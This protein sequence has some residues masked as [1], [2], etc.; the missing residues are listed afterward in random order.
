[1]SNNYKR[2]PRRKSGKKFSVQ[3]LSSQVSKLLARNPKTRY[4]AKQ[5]IKKLKISNSKDSVAH[6]LNELAKDGAIIQ[7]KEGLYKWNRDNTVEQAQKV[8]PKKVYT[9]IVDLIQSGAAY[10]IV[11]DEEQ[12]IYIPKKFLR[13]AMNNDIVRVEMANIPGKRKPE[14]KVVDIIERSVTH[15]MGQLKETNKYGIVYPL[16][17]RG[18]PDEVYIKH[19]NFNGA[20]DGD[21]VVAEIITWG[22]SQN[23]A[24]W[25]KVK[26]IVEPANDSDIAMQSI[27]LNNGFEIEFPQQVLDQIKPMTAD[28]TPEEEKIRRDVRPVTTFTIDPLTARDFDD[29]LSFQILDDGQIEVGIHIA[30]VT[31]YVKENSPLDKEAR[32]RSTSVYLVDRVCPMLPEKL[33]NDLC[34][35]NPHVDRYTFSAIFTFDKDFKVTNRWFGKTIIHSDRRFT[36]EEAQEV[37]ESGKGDYADELLKLNE[38]AHKL[39]KDKYKN[40]AISFESDEIRF[41]LDDQG[42]PIGVTVKERKDAHMLVEDFM[43]LANREV[44]TFVAKK[45]KPEIPFTYRV[46]DHPNPEKLAD[47]AA[48][49]SELGFKMKLD[50]PKQIAK[51]FNKLAKEAEHNEQ[52]RMLEPLAIRTMSKAIYTVGNIGHYGLG[53]E[54]YAHFTSPIRRYADV[55]VHRILHANLSKEYRMKKDELE[56]INQHISK[57]ERNA[58]EAE[59]ASIKYKQVEYV[60]DQIGEVK[61]AYISGMIDRGIFVAIEESRAEGLVPFDRFTES[62]EVSDSRFIAVGRKTGRKL[63]M[64]DKVRVKILDADLESRQIEMEIV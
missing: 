40:G 1:M 47:F 43:L 18:T 46:H 41:E 64:G 23:K 12:D 59:R 16:G 55:L 8:L 37:L 38:I 3:F 4:T 34:S 39:R 62:F 31:H 15:V 22:S 7:L 6:A 25:A 26:R 21:Y 19:K 63:K 50:T 51:S 53:F 30:D 42:K 10:V 56:T 11:D 24:L 29:A 45:S 61:D 14:G 33:S 27:L 28:I 35:L 52:L 54:Y 48:F 5:V 20:E 17:G 60:M 13:G 32:E 2:K 57:Q 58:M 9:G 36:Y 44:A 49:A